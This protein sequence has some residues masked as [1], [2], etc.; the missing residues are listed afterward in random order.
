[1]LVHRP[2]HHLEYVARPIHL[3][4]MLVSRVSVGNLSVKYDGDL[5]HNPV[6]HHRRDFTRICLSEEKAATWECKYLFEPV[7]EPEGVRDVLELAQPRHE[8]VVLEYLV[9]LALQQRGRFEGA[10]LRIIARIFFDDSCV[11]KL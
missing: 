7:C 8:F 4:E 6:H 3:G 9:A 5:M 10:G 2:V 1:M 11:E